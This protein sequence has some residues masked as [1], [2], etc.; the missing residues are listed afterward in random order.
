MN[1][2]NIHL[3]VA[4]LGLFVLSAAGCRTK[5]I[6]EA[7]ANKSSA[8]AGDG[9]TS[10]ARQRFFSM[11]HERI[12]KI[13]GDY[14]QLE[15]WGREKPD[16]H[17]TASG[18]QTTHNQLSY[19]HNMKQ[20]GTSNYMDSYDKNG[21][22]ISVKVYTEKEFMMVA[23]VGVKTMIFGRKMGEYRLIASVITENP[24]VPELEDKIYEI[25]R[26]CALP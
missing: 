20:A 8:V 1:H 14:P 19:S 3:T 11:L 4:V 7:G 5:P 10:D 15:A 2:M 21:C 13:A 12:G 24:E 23:G 26:S 9:E 18:R 22:H 16:A 6:K 25:I 17:W